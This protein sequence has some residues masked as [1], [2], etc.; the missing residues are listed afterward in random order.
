MSTAPNASGGR[1]DPRPATPAPAEPA[2]LGFWR[3]LIA[4]GA[5]WFTKTPPAVLIVQ[6]LLILLVGGLCHMAWVLLY[7]ANA[8]DSP[9]PPSRVLIASLRTVLTVL[10]SLHKALFWFGM[11]VIATALARI[12]GERRE[13]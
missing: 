1:S 5:G 4:A 7:E 8:Y 6:G 12:I 10:V 13:R 11:V 2:D 3:G 9:G